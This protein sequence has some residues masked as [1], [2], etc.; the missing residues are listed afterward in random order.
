MAS[1]IK[2]GLVVQIDW[3]PRRGSEQGGVR[4]AVIVQNDIGN[5]TSPTTIVVASTTAKHKSYPFLVYLKAGEA[6][7]PEESTINC[8][9]IL[10]VDKTC[11]I[12][13][14]GFVPEDKMKE[15]DR[16]LLV[17]LGIKN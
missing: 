8:S 13:E 7:L 17:S 10:T 5:K 16:A 9:A 15:I 12:G 3:N 4:P 11:I 1:E 2:R 14:Y 6:G